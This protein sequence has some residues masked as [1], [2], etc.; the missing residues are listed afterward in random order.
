M[1]HEEMQA[2]IDKD[3]YQAVL[4]CICVAM[5]AKITPLSIGYDLVWEK[6]KDLNM[7]AYKMDRVRVGEAI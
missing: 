6:A 7:L 3:G 2:L 4:N 5:A 1:N